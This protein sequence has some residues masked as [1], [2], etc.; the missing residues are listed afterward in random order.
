MIS[1]RWIVVGTLLLYLVS[2]Y[3][4]QNFTALAETLMH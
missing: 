4:V 1:L 2:M 3:I